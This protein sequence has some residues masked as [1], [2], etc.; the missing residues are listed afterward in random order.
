M[1]GK[2]G[3]LARLQTGQPFLFFPVVVVVAGS[4]WTPPLEVLGGAALA[5]GKGKRERGARIG[6]P[7]LLRRLKEKGRGKKRGWAWPG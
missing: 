3:D 7:A 2:R 6:R 4:V 1:Q 5:H